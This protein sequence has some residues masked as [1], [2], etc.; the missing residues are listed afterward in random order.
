MAIFGCVGCGYKFEHLVSTAWRKA[1]LRRRDHCPKCDT[2]QL[3]SFVTPTGVVGTPTPF[4][5]TPP[6]MAALWWRKQQYGKTA[7]EPLDAV[8]G[9]GR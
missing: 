4:N 2:M 7:S 3:F 6:S 1:L 8:F 9:K 5:D